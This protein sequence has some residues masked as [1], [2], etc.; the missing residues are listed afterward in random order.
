[1]RG[2]HAGSVHA[3][4][5][6]LGCGKGGKRVLKLRRCLNGV[7]LNKALLH[8]HLLVNVLLVLKKDFL[9]LTNHIHSLRVALANSKQSLKKLEECRAA[10][11]GRGGVGL[12]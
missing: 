8:L 1:M 12:I 3:K 9:A 6:H 5:D 2:R 7:E 4:V 11:G 10:R